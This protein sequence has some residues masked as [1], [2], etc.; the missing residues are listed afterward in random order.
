MIRNF[1]TILFLVTLV[2][3]VFADMLDGLDQHESSK[4][5]VQHEV[6][7]SQYSNMNST[8]QS[9]DCNNCE[10]DDCHH[11]EGHCIHHCT[12]IHH[13]IIYTASLISLKDLSSYNNKVA[14]YYYHHYKSP[15]P[16]PALKP[17]LFS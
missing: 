5:R 1:L 4:G 3:G 17:P 12:G 14:W 16:D 2:S 9:E 7:K 6:I 15:Y 8:I 13:I 10:S 11:E